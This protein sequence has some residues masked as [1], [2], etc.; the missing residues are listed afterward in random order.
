M[1]AYAAQQW[2]PCHKYKKTANG[3]NTNAFVKGIAVWLLLKH[4]T[5]SGKIQGYRDQLKQLAYKCKMCVRSLDKYIA[6]LRDEQLATVEGRDLLLEGYKALKQYGINIRQREQTINY[7]TTSKATLA[8]IIIALGIEK[9]K[10]K[11][12]DAYWQ[13][14]TK[15]QD[16]LGELRNHLIAYGADQQRLDNPEY[17][18]QCHLRLLKLTYKE[19]GPGQTSFYLLHKYIQA[20]PDI[21]MK[22]ATYA[23][24]MGYAVLEHQN[25]ATRKDESKSMG[26][27][28]LKWR[29][30]TKGLIIIS[31][32]Q[33]ESDYRARKDEKI[34]HHRYVRDT[35]RTIWFLPDQLNINHAEIFKTTA[36]A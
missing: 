16:A 31:K 4:E 29:L 34:F 36:A 25:Q 24:K 10:D 9:M 8:E 17:F 18:R 28:H 33:V 12:R 3:K 27:S 32:D 19:A 22:A 6:W 23:R 20:N 35:K 15:N 30:A 14:V 2:L 5:P 7:D 13:K 21:N 11:P 26:F 1:I